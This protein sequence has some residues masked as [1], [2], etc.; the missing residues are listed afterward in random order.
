MKN[1]STNLIAVITS[2]FSLVNNMGKAVRFVQR[3]VLCLPLIY[4][5][6]HWCS[7]WVLSDNPPACLKNFLNTWN[8]KIQAGL[9]K[10]PALRFNV[11]WHV[12]HLNTRNYSKSP[13]TL[14]TY[15]D[16]VQYLTPKRFWEKSHTE[17]QCIIPYI[18][19][20]YRIFFKFQSNTVNIY[21]TRGN[22]KFETATGKILVVSFI[23]TQ[24]FPYFNTTH[25]FLEF[26]SK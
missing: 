22:S 6:M 9:K 10:R 11:C 19:A 23:V 5:F 26:D 20:Q 7:M 4:Y 13:C 24:V 25:Q 12:F 3:T 1:C 18:G 17:L 16:H 15:I 14:Q 2:F 21:W 8:I